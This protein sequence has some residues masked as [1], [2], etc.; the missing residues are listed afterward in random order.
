M[1]KKKIAV[2]TGAGISAESGIKTFRDADGLWENHDVMEVASIEGW[3][4]NPAL[5]MEFYNARRK[6]LGE[7]EPN[8]G[9]TALIDLEEHFEVTIVTQNVD[10]LHERA[11]SKNIIHLHGELSKVRSLADPR[12]IYDVGDRPIQ[13][14]DTCE[15]GG[16]LRPHIVWFGEMVPMMEPAT[17]VVLEADILMVIGTSLNVYP[18]AGLLDYISSDTPLYVVD[19]NIPPI[20]RHFDVLRTFEEK[21][22]IGVPMAVQEIIEKYA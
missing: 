3:N 12:I 9:H 14:G 7:V 18:A 4:K 21:A 11:G 2:L 6:Q 10:N 13:L 20:G 15:K 19:P 22:G 16:Q 17:R 5:V 1:A 8:A